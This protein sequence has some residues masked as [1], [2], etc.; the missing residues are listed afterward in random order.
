MSI[1]IFSANGLHIQVFD[2]MCYVI[3]V[4]ELS[5]PDFIISS[6][7]HSREG[8]AAKSEKLIRYK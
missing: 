2:L 7:S 4:L 8:Q 5:V 6:I 3:L 1:R